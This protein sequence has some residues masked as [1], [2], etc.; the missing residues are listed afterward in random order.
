MASSS[1]TQ[2]LNPPIIVGG[3]L[4]ADGGKRYHCTF[5]GCTKSYRKPVRLEEHERTHTG[6][7]PFVCTTCRKTYFR[8]S[9]LQAHMRTHMPDSSRSFAC[10]FDGCEKKFWT[11]QH[12]KRHEETHSGEKPFK[13]SEL[14][15]SQ[16]FSKHNQ[17]RS[18]ISSVHCQSGTKN[19]RC[20]HEGCPKSFATSQKLKAHAK[21]HEDHRYTCTHPA[22]LSKSENEYFSAWSALQAH[23][24]ATHP[25]TCPYVSCNGKIFSQQKILRVHLKIHEQREAEQTLAST[26]R[27]DGCEAD[28]EGEDRPSKRSR[29]GE[30]GRDWKC[31]ESGCEKDFKSKKALATHVKVAHMLRRDFV[32]TFE[33][34]GAS[35]GYKHLLQRHSARIHSIHGDSHGNL[36]S[37]VLDEVPAEGCTPL[38]T[39][40]NSVIDVLTGKAYE[41]HAKRRLSATETLACPYPVIPGH[42]LETSSGLSSAPCKF[43]FSRAYDL[44]RHLASAHAL[45][46]DREQ[47]TE[48]VKALRRAAKA[49]RSCIDGLDLYVWSLIY[50]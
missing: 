34:C 24:R 14:G 8:D 31:S 29:G 13:C 35:F 9:H 42:K 5:E 3:K 39:L 25:P 10:Q 41:D 21:I 18:H 19:F 30:V 2:V 23:T 45:N 33:G 50:W 43:V 4:I 17:L 38:K 22:C 15:C 12:L 36:H 6:E 32:C 11:P 7:R 27:G 44:R 1:K 46:I 47:A 40:E 20:E 26:Y 37:V 28:D 49:P 48:V 16:S